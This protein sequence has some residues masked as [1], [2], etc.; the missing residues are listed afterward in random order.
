[1]PPVG[2]TDAFF[3]ASFGQSLTWGG[4]SSVTDAETGE[5]VTD[6][7]I[8]SES[9]FDYRNPAPELGD[10]NGDDVANAADIDL[11]C[12]AIRGGG[13]VQPYD[14][15]GDG[16]VDM[17]DL[18]FEVQTLIGTN[19]GDTD[20]DGDVDL[21]DLGNLA[22]NYEQSAP[23]SWG[24]GDFD[25]DQDVDLSDLGAL[26]T[27]Y[28]QGQAR[29]YAEFSALTGIEVPEPSGGV[30]VVAI[31]AVALGRRRRSLT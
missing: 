7:T 25:C 23:R 20:V 11:L 30:V 27:Y 19:Y 10:L 2:T 13:P 9:G 15:D 16:N 4:I 6:W 1:L 3:S 21:S 18:A 28:G 24:Q 12:A 5:P 26:A 29:A 22:T 17:D 31:A 8:T 14:V